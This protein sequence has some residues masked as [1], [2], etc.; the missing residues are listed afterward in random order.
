MRTAHLRDRTFS[1]CGFQF[2]TNCNH[3]GAVKAN[4]SG[5]LICY[6]TCDLSV[7]AGTPV[8]RSFYLGSMAEVTSMEQS[9]WVQNKLIT[10]TTVSSMFYH[11]LGGCLKKIP[12]MTQGALAPQSPLGSIHT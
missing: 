11:N 8:G 9:R 10:N 6:F 3:L 7:A 5:K 2:S 4:S 12:L 1:Y